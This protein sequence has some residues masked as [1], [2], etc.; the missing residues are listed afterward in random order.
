MANLDACYF[1]LKL[2][3]TLMCNWCKV[4]ATS[5]K[6][7][8][9]LQCAEQLYEELQFKEA[10]DVNYADEVLLHFAK[11]ATHTGN[12]EKRN[13]VQVYIK[14]IAFELLKVRRGRLA[15]CIK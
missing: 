1:A 9:F 7:P 15:T 6:H 8:N 11:A 12:W 10:I 13:A 5:F 14:E 2:N 3:A 4:N